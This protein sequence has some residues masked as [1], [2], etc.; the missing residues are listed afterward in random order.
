LI[1]QITDEL[2]RQE[3]RTWKKVIRVISHELNNSLA[4]I[5]SLAHSGAELVKRG[6]HEQLAKVFTTIAERS[7][8][9]EQFILGY[10]R[11]AKLP[12]PR[13]EPIAWPE[14]V[15]RLRSQIAFQVDGALPDAPA[16]VDST[17]L[18]QALV[19]LLQNA[20]ESGSPAD[21]IHLRIRR[22]PH[23]VVL[24]VCDRGGGMSEAVLSNALLPFY[25]TK[26]GGTGLGLA[27]VR[28]ITEAHGGRVSLTNR[29][30]G[31]VRVTI[32]IPQ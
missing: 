25:S 18:E 12:T 20:H 6:K 2:R 27:L 15:E 29:Q 21:A 30:D 1:R 32:T 9:L 24:D 10:A 22:M 13:P 7:R 19:N 11:F 16:R 26:R 5:A 3:V 4:P 28:E 14:L 23:A 17:Q 31:G 8:H